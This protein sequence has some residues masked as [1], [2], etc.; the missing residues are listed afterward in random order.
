M[1]KEPLPLATAV[2]LTLAVLVVPTFAGDL[3]DPSTLNEQAPDVYRARFETSKGVPS[4]L[5]A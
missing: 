1:K 4:L 5:F 2:I 3:K